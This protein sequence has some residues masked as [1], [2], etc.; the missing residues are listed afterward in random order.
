[1]PG[2]TKLKV[3]NGVTLTN[4]GKIYVD[5][6]LYGSSG[7]TTQCYTNEVCGVLEIASGAKVVVDKDINNK[8][9]SLYAYGV[10]RGDGEIV[11]NDGTIVE[12]FTILDWGGGTSANNATAHN[13]SPFNNWKADNIR[14]KTIMKTGVEYA[15]FGSVNIDDEDN[16]VDFALVGPQDTNTNPLFLMHP[17]A[18]IQKSYENGDFHLTVLEGKVVDNE[19]EISF[20]IKGMTKTINF[21]KIPIP[22]SAFD[23]TIASGAEIELNQN[24]YK[25]LP[26]SD[27]VVNGKMTI[28]TTVAAYDNYNLKLIE[29]YKVGSKF[30]L[31]VVGFGVRDKLTECTY[32]DKTLSVKYNNY[33]FTWLGESLKGSGASSC[34]VQ[35][36]PT[37][38]VGSPITVNGKLILGA[39]AIFTGDITSNT[40][41][42]T[43]EVKT[44]AKFTNSQQVT[45]VNGNK[46][47][48][49]GF[50]EGVGFMTSTGASID[51]ASLT[52]GHWQQSYAVDVDLTGNF[53]R[54]GDLDFS[55]IP[56]G[57]AT[58]TYNGSTWD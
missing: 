19:K 35:I 49:H 46:I 25:I 40:E 20:T 27:V 33:E 2:H 51:I 13:A 39:K 43:I 50:A 34:A 44:G 37:D 48:I 8:E 57:E 15:A 17:G 12:V 11:A 7:I 10:V 31:N 14:V 45:D 9:G 4:Y 23:I 47:T 22:L 18:T 52:Y 58:Y 28:N 41:L 6:Q 29:M 53:I 42:A 38:R 5:G 1:M 21:K 55:Q 54:S 26:G 56:T 24:L 30:E 16:K 36:Y 32:T 3:A